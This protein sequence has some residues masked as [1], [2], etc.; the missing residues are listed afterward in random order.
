MHYEEDGGGGWLSGVV[1]LSEYNTAVGKI[2]AST[3]FVL[4]QGSVSF[5]FSFNALIE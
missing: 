2:P 3:L 1:P 5:F 4:M